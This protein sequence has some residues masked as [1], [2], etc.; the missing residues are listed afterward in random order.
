ML[1]GAIAFNLLLCIPGFTAYV[2]QLVVLLF[3]FGSAVVV[4]RL[5]PKNLTMVP[6]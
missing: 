1:V 5:F 3:F 2:W 4:T 6:S